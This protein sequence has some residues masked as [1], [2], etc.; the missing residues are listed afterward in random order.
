[1]KADINITPLIDVILVLLIIFML[2]A[3][4]APRALDAALPQPA[5]KTP[6]PPPPATALLLEVDDDGLRLNHSPIASLADL[7][8]RLQSLFDARSDR[9]LFVRAAGGVS[10]GSVVE[11]LDVARGAGVERIGLV[12]RPPA[13]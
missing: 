5:S 2:V 3:P 4:V 8:T 6:T 1:M 9:T 10:Y 7:A 11:A 13:P 12:G